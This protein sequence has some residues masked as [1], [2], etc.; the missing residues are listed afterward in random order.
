M[1]MPWSFLTRR[2][3]AELSPT[4]IAEAKAAFDPGGVSSDLL[5]QPPA[6]VPSP[7][8][9]TDTAANFEDTSKSLVPAQGRR[10]EA[11]HAVAEKAEVQSSP[12]AI[13][14]SSRRGRPA[15]RE[16]RGLVAVPARDSSAPLPKADMRAVK[17]SV[18][19]PTPNESFVI[20]ASILDMEI[21]RLRRE[22][23]E[24]L[25]LQNAQLREMLQRFDPS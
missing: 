9:P 25:K 5:E 4:E 14:P 20:H 18:P 1:K 19:E 6:A 2:R 21:E 8:A 10:E 11:E 23:A 22:L 3:T 7:V 13:K 24:K 17:S 16:Q 15:T 12:P